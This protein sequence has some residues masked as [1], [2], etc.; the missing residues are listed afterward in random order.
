MLLQG[1]L[2]N[3]SKTPCFLVRWCKWG[4]QGCLLWGFPVRIVGRG[5]APAAV[6]RRTIDTNGGTQGP[7]L[8]C[9]RKI[10]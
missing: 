9:N 10:A 8:R 4:V 7:A 2:R 6:T 3:D 1:A 5:L